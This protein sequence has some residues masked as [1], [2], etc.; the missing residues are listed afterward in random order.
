MRE[1]LLKRTC[2][3]RSNRLL[4]P[5][6]TGK[7]FLFRRVPSIVKKG[8]LAMKKRRNDRL[9]FAVAGALL[10]GTSSAAFAQSPS[11]SSGQNSTSAEESKNLAKHKLAAYGL[12]DPK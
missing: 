10:L 5:R 11:T 7:E 2:T 4:G 3:G 6:G 1:N 8:S 12:T 9:A